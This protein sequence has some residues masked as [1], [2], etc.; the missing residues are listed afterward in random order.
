MPDFSE[1]EILSVY[2]SKIDKIVIDEIVEI[3]KLKQPAFPPKPNFIPAKLDLSVY[4][5]F[6]RQQ[7]GAGCWGYSML[8]VWDI[9]NEMKCPFSPNLSMR[10][11]MMLH[12]RRELWEKQGGLFSPDGRFHKMKNPE[13]GFL[14]SFGDTTE[15]TELTLHQHPSLWPDGGWSQEGVNEAENYKL[16]SEP[17][18]I[19]VS[20]KDFVNALAEGFPIR[21]RIG[22]ADPDPKKS[23]GHFVAVVGY[24]TIAKTFKYVNSVGDKWGQDGFS[25]YTFKEIDDHKS[26]SIDIDQGEIIEIVVPKPVPAARISFTHTNRSNV[27]LWLSAED[28]PLPKRKIWPQGWSENSRNL[29]FTVRLPKEFIWPPSQNNRLVLDLYDSAEYSNSGGKLEEFTVAFGGH[30]IKCAALSNGPCG[31]NARE[32]KHFLIP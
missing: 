9:M 12:R 30:V 22:Y 18:K 3:E 24:D 23:W 14:Q 1:K 5:R 26:G 6:L 25:T 16:K 27:H 8:A 28:S 29:S 13:F 19:N 10:L 15:G 4:L 17:Q 2:D 11:W 7:G 21:L 20:S 31:F 32:Y